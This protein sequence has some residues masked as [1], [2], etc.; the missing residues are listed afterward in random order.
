[1]SRVQEQTDYSSNDEDI[2]WIKR[3]RQGDK[4]AIDR[5]VLKYQ[6]QI[7]NLCVHVL[8]NHTDGEDAAQE[9]FVKVYKNLD[10]FKGEALFLTWL[11]RITVN[12]CRNKQRSWWNRFS[13]R[14]VKLDAPIKG[15]GSNRIREIGDTS[16]SPE[17]ELRRHRIAE[18]VK[19]ALASLPKKHRE[20]IVLR[21]IQE[22]SYE[23]IGKVLD[24]SLGTVKSR[25]ARARSAM[26]EKLRGKV[27]GLY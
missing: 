8:G 6:N 12:T 16:L 2:S 24:L 15:D 10:T 4:T 1:M 21:D 19:E 13:R 5:L 14:A 23:E 3:Y 22:R 27:N 20:L 26:Q 18:R 11:Y 17:N 9:T 25:L 7:M